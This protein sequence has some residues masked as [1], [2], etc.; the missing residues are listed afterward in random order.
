MIWTP[1]AT[2]ATIVENDG[3]FLLVEERSNNADVI[4]QPAGHVEKGESIIDAAI[5]ETLEETGWL[6]S[7]EYLVGIYTYTAPYNDITYYRFCFA[8]STV[9]FLEDSPIDSDIQGQCWLTIDEINQKQAMHRGPLVAL[10]IKDYLDGKQF[11]LSL[12]Y[13]HPEGK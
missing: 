8:A 4:N 13:E 5:R 1:H 3:K 12:I 10:C 11:P 7:P 9:K 2:V 6:V